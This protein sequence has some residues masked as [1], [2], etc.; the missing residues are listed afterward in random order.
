MTLRPN[1]PPARPPHQVD[2]RLSR[3]RLCGSAAALW[4]VA[5]L[6]AQEAELR[7]FD[8]QRGEE[9]VTLSFAIAYELPRSVEDA[10]LKGV[11]LYFVARAELWHSRW[12]WR[13]RRVAVAERVWRLAFQP[14]TR[15]YRVSF[16]GLNQNFDLLG[17]ALASTRRITDWKVAEPGQIEAGVAHYLQFSY[18]L[19]T[20]LLP[21]PLQIG[22]GGQPD[23]S[24]RLERSHRLE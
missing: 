21:R 24:L 9:G 4:L 20:S 16:G 15:K 19:D 3:R 11:P 1:P 18:R 8:V 5:P 22:I 17:E 6:H 23:W 12:Y 10:L 2:V 13:D 7:Q 14:L